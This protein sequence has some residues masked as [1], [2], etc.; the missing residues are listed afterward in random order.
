MSATSYFRP[1]ACPPAEVLVAYGCGSLSEQLLAQAANHLTSCSAC[2]DTMRQ[3]EG[4]DDS[5]I[6]HLRR[7]VPEQ[8]AT[9]RSEATPAPQAASASPGAASEGFGTTVVQTREASK[10]VDDSALPRTFAGYE[11]LEVLGH[12]GMGTVYKAWQTALERLVALKVIASESAAGSESQARFRVEAKAVA[13]L[14][15][16]HVVQIYDFGEENGQPYFSMEIMEGGSLKDRLDGKQQ[17]ERETADLVRAVALGVHAA[18]RQNIIHRDLKPGNVLLDRDGTPKISDFGLAKLLDAEHSQ[19]LTDVV[20]GTPAYMAPEQ[21]CG[22]GAVGPLSDVYALGVILYEMLTGKQPFRGASRME[23]LDQVRHLP[24]PLVSHLR[25]GV[26]ADLEAVCSKCLEKDAQRRYPSAEALADDLGRWLRG[27]STRARPL[28]RPARVWRSVKRHP[29]LTAAAVLLLVIGVTAVGAAAY[30]DPERQR[31][32]IDAEIRKG[33]K[34]V[35]IGETG[36]PRWTGWRSGEGI[37]RTGVDPVGTFYM[38]SAF[39]NQEVARLELASFTQRD[40]YRFEAEVRHDDSAD[41]G[42]VGVFFASRTDERKGRS[43]QVFMLLTFNEITVQ[44]SRFP[45]AA[46]AKGSG[47]NPLYMAGRIFSPRANSK[48]CDR[49]IVAMNQGVFTPVGMARK[50]WR[51]LTIEVT[52]ERVRIYLDG[53]LMGDMDPAKMDRDL[54]DRMPV[55]VKLDPNLFGPNPVPPRLNLRGGVGLYVS[56]SSASFRNVTLEPME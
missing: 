56:R 8:S 13:R 33:G 19:T 41:A 30:L 43:L 29:M 49:D 17:P 20:M 42:E 45:A 14:R 53:N 6:N 44:K 11:L 35:L 51:K 34:V 9:L 31:A 48:N 38:S 23:T 18:H 39:N 3:L 25:P 1:N 21:V 46:L 7:Y 16:P 47:K 22:T 37:A 2:L 15:D 36:A 54:A 32:A 5:L 27:E 24:A 28:S 50:S 26:S 55:L 4:S 52:P 10:K 40:R 12:G